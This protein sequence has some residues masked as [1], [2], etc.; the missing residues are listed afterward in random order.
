MKKNVGLML[1]LFLGVSFLSA[2]FAQDVPTA[3]ASSAKNQAID[4]ALEKSSVSSKK[5]M[6]KHSKKKGY[7]KGQHPHKK[8]KKSKR[9]KKAHHKKA[10]VKNQDNSTVQ[11]PIN[12]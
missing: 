12:N 2:A 7:I 9:T 1:A 8:L 6:K 5:S 11:T 3:P 10:V 4:S